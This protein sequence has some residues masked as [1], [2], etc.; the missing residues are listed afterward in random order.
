MLKQ[1]LDAD[2]YDG[3]AHYVLAYV[4]RDNQRDQDAVR[5]FRLAIENGNKAGMQETAWYKD[6][7]RAEAALSHKLGR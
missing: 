5:E 2:F 4:W 6:A 1:V 3:E 7:A